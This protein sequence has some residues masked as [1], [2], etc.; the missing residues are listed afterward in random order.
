MFCFHYLTGISSFCTS[1][2]PATFIVIDQIKEQSAVHQQ[3]DSSIGRR[4]LRILRI[5]QI[6]VCGQRISRQHNVAFVFYLRQMRSQVVSCRYFAIEFKWF[7][8]TMQL[9]RLRMDYYLI[10]LTISQCNYSARI[11]G[12][13]IVA[14]MLC[15][16]MKWSIC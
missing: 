8:R 9:H 5:H 6:P 14:Q 12:G 1:P 4:H 10:L 13:M 11:P 3:I 16:M 7:D 2:T 15:R